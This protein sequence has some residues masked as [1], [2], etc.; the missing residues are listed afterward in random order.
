MVRTSK[1]P[2][3][4]EASGSYSGTEQGKDRRSEERREKG[5]YG[6]PAEDGPGYQR[7]DKQDGGRYGIERAVNREEGDEGSSESGG[8]KG[9]DFDDARQALGVADRTAQTPK[10]DKPRRP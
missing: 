2:E 5:V 10:R 9:A 7:E 6:S 1:Q 4:S 8:D 3:P